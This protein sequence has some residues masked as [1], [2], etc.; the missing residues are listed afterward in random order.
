VSDARVRRIEEVDWR[1]LRVVRLRALADSPDAF[2]STL[3]REA[4]F[5][6][7][8]WQEWARRAAAGGDETCL[9]A[10][11][12]EEPVG[13]VAAYV[14]DGRDHVHL[15]AMWVEAGARRRG[16]GRQLVEAVV[17][18]ST[19]SGPSKIRLDVMVGNVEARRLYESFGFAPTGRTERYEDRPHL[20][21]IELE[22][23]AQ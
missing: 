18:W 22:R 23:A 1:A 5:G 16:L 20:T 12:E 15:I 10:W 4:R 6:D 8:D 11:I 2:G 21:T 7:A 13:I 3:E 14:E 9:L 19:E 17:S